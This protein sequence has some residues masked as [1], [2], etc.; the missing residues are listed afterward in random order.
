[1]MNNLQWMSGDNIPAPYLFPVLQQPL[2]EFYITLFICFTLAFLT[3]YL[4]DI[5]LKL[6]R[7]TFFDY[8]DKVLQSK[9]HFTKV[10]YYTVKTIFF[11][12][13]S[14]LTIFL[15]NLKDIKTD[16]N[17]NIFTFIIEVILYYFVWVINFHIFWRKDLKKIKNETFTIFNVNMPQ[18]D[19]KEIN[20]LDDNHNSYTYTCTSYDPC[21]NKKTLVDI[22]KMWDKYE[23]LKPYN[24]IKFLN[25]IDDKLDV[26]EMEK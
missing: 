18:K 8:G 21:V 14:F 10:N 26:K 1:M 11:I 7:Y 9:V 6:K 5:L 15:L 3:T 17:I 4:T 22:D 23:I 25:S 20:T 12:T 24:T 19:F 16:C 2:Q 13:I